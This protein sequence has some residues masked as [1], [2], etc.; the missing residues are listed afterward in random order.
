MVDG[1]IRTRYPTGLRVAIDRVL[2]ISERLGVRPWGRREICLFAEGD[3]TDPNVQLPEGWKERLAG[4]AARRGWE[5][6]EVEEPA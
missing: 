1:T 4:E 2:E 3:G 6:Y 5:S